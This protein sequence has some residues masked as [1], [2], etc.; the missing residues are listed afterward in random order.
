M[1]LIVHE[2]EAAGISQEVTATANVIVRAIRP[3][4]YRHNMPAGK[5]KIEIYDSGNTLIS[6]SE[7]LDISNIG[8]ADFFHGY[9][10]FYVDAYL[11]KDQT[12]TFELVGHDGYSFSES[13]Y[14]G[15][16]NGFDLAKY[17]ASTT[18]ANK[19]SYPLDFEVWELT[20]K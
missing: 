1:K 19:F 2:L 6:T 9:V 8:S 16:C 11:S 10:R 12:Y 13:S 18:P 5:L 15:W 3:H 17:P 14:I 4:I 7:S 20:S